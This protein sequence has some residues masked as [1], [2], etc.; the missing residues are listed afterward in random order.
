VVPWIA[1]SCSK[2]KEKSST[3]DV[4]AQYPRCFHTGVEASVELARA[5]AFL[6]QPLVGLEGAG[7]A[8]GERV[9]V[10]VHGA[11]QEVLPNAEP[12]VPSSAAGPLRG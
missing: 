4:R 2:M 7:E 3:L 6:P 10:G 11:S 9:G 12:A 1:A 5:G 8:E